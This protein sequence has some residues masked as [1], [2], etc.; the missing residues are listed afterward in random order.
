MERFIDL[1]SFVFGLKLS[2]QHIE[3][4][5]F[6][7]KNSREVILHPTNR[8]EPKIRLEYLT[9]LKN[10]NPDNDIFTAL[11]WLRRGLAQRD[12]VETFSALMVCL[13]IMARKLAEGRPQEISC[14]KN[15]VIK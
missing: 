11:Y 5:I 15:V 4:C 3:P 6:K 1:L 2:A 8:A 9:D 7:N 10:I 14:P 13:Q 12:A